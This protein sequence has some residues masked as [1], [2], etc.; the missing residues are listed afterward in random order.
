MRGECLLVLNDARKCCIV[1]ETPD[2]S[3]ISVIW[4]VIFGSLF[5]VHLVFPLLLVPW[6]SNS[7]LQRFQAVEEYHLEHMKTLIGSYVHSVEDTH[8]Q[9]GQVRE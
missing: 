5:P 8:V 6:S 3:R 1:G 7:Y 2:D 9:I 4:K